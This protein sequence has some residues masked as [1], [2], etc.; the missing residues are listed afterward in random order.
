MDSF[1]TDLDILSAR[2]REK[3]RAFHLDGH[4]DTFVLQGTNQEVIFPASTIENHG[5]PPQHQVR[6]YPAAVIPTRPF[7]QLDCLHL[8]LAF[9]VGA[10]LMFVFC[11]PTQ[12]DHHH[13]PQ[14]RDKEKEPTKQEINNQN[15]TSVCTTKV[16]VGHT[17]SSPAGETS[18]VG[19]DND[20]DD[21][22]DDTPHLIPDDDGHQ[23]HHLVE[24][25]QQQP[26]ERQCN[27]QQ[28]ALYPV[29]FSTDMITDVA[30]VACNAVGIP[31]TSNSNSTTAIVQ[32]PLTTIKNEEIHEIVRATAICKQSSREIGLQVDD[33]TLLK[34]MSN[35]YDEKNRAD[36][37]LL[38]EFRGYAFTHTQ[39]DRKLEVQEKQHRE[40]IAVQREE[41]DWRKKLHA[42]ENASTEVLV[43][44]TAQCC[45]A[46][47]VS[48]L[49]VPLVQA[50]TA[51]RAMDYEELFCYGSGTDKDP[52]VYTPPQVETTGSELSVPSTW[53]GLFDYNYVKKL[54][55]NSKVLAWPS[56]ENIVGVAFGD[57]LSCLKV[58]V[59]RA[60]GYGG[61]IVVLGVL[62]W[63]IPKA[64]FPKTIQL[65]FQGFILIGWL[66]LTKLVPEPPVREVITCAAVFYCG[67][68]ACLKYMSKKAKRV[69]EAKKNTPSADEV[70]KF[71]FGFTEASQIFKL[72]PWLLCPLLL[73]W[74]FFNTEEVV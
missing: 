14:T 51:V 66:I 4:D 65:V 27:Q 63:V 10:S 67:G 71:C 9:L 23:H 46:A 19:T 34:A 30:T 43:R 29:A 73:V 72:M 6:V 44:S 57:A 15:D 37:E 56:A 31:M 50:F 22:D 18:I 40:N 55:Y 8:I 17:S 35:H 2:I 60:L 28:L 16:P 5:T 21:D 53:S 33:N 68:S 42:A 49:V 64:Q 61:A 12:S 13:H 52:L 48:S 74:P 45:F 62:L 1:E 58:T 54:W 24:K 39:N 70:N 11:R 26:P 25:Q 59:L 3:A 7:H 69:L 32:Q 38:K 41:P 20:A 36:R 47:L